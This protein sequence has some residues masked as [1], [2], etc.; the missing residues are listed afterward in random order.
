MTACVS[1][2]QFLNVRVH[3]SLDGHFR[4][5]KKSTKDE[6]FFCTH[7]FYRTMNFS[8]APSY[9]FVGSVSAE[10]AIM[11]DAGS[12]GTRAYIYRWVPTPEDGI[13]PTIEAIPAVNDENRVTPG[14]SSLE[15]EEEIRASFVPLLAYCERTVPQAQRAD[16]PMYLKGT[17]PKS[18]L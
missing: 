17:Y 11:F 5:R 18:R 12:S 13:I 3:V 1:E 16:T 15:T 9:R 14:L 7:Q 4:T 2:S 6:T 10:Y 8:S